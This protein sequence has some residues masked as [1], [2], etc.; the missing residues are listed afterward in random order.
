MEDILLLV[1]INSSTCQP[2]DALP[3]F[4]WAPLGFI[5]GYA[6]KYTG[7]T[8][9]FVCDQ[10]ALSLPHTIKFCRDVAFRSV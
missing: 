6:V 1:S 3:A 5:R 8:S 10:A 2:A 9:A 4:L 7:A